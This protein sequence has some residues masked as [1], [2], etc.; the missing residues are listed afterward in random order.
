MD[1]VVFFETKFLTEV[2]RVSFHSSNAAV[3]KWMQIDPMMS[4][5]EGQ[6]SVSRFQWGKL[7]E[8]ITRGY[9]ISRRWLNMWN[10]NELFLGLYT[11]IS[12]KPQAMFP[13]L[14]VA[15]N[16][17]LWAF[18]CGCILTFLDTLHV[19]AIAEASTFKFITQMASGVESI[20][21]KCCWIVNYE[22]SG[23]VA[24]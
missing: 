9:P 1:T 13:L 19:S 24:S 22:L 11:T 6:P 23:V 10:S 17:K 4:A 5:A 7:P 3:W 16:S 14:L 18:W 21:E 15:S 8:E 12:L 20:W 2:H